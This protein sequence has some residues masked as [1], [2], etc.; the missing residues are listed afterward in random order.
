M[1]FHGREANEWMQALADDGESRD[2]VS[3][4]LVS[5]E[6][7]AEERLQVKRLERLIEAPSESSGRRLGAKQLALVAGVFAAALAL[8]ATMS[9]EESFKSI[10]EPS[11]VASLP[12][13]EGTVT[14]EEGSRR[15]S[16]DAGSRLFSG[17]RVY[18]SGAAALTFLSGAQVR[19]QDGAAFGLISEASTEGLHLSDGRVSLQIPKQ[20]Q[21][22]TWSVTTASA[23]ITV[24]GTQFAVW[25][26]DDRGAQV[27]CVQ[28]S[29]GR[30][31][32][33]STAHEVL[34][35]AGQT[36]SSAPES[37]VCFPAQ[38]V[39]NVET[40]PPESNPL[41]KSGPG[42]E[43]LKKASSAS[44]L[45]AQNKLFLGI[46]RARREGQSDETKRL[47]ERFLQSYPDSPLASQVRREIAR[48][49]GVDAP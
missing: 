31:R 35:S 5:S 6:L 32:A 29:E 4:S 2:S 1:T 9:Q 8:I 19:M 40:P 45:A 49:E 34:L 7:S 47:G 48:V 39:E 44:S 23:K 27:T 21:G 22:T 46:V 36:W 42:A 3:R 12:T 17:D 16:L 25:L 14:K 20:R 24:V 43:A 10:P 37:Q 13:I 38:I 11:V 18:S 41:P 33:E 15:I 28:V 30:V 26:A